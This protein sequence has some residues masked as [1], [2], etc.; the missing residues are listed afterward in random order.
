MVMSEEAVTCY[1]TGC[2]EKKFV[3]SANHGTACTFHPAVPIFHDGIKR[4]PCCKRSS[5]DFT[6]LLSYPGCSSGPHNPTRPE[7]PAPPPA[8]LIEDA[9]E[10]PAVVHQPLETRPTP[11]RTPSGSLEP[12][13]TSTMPS[14]V[15]ALNRMTTNESLASQAAPVK[16]KCENFG[17]DAEFVEGG[18][19]A[20]NCLHH[21]SPPVFHEGLQYWG[22]CQ[23]KH[24]DFE[25]MRQQPGCTHGKH[26][27]CNP[28]VKKVSCRFD[29]FDNPS[30]LTLNIYAKN[31]FPDKC[32]FLANNCMLRVNL[33]YGPEQLCF[34]K[35]FRLFSTIDPKRCVVNLNATK[36]EVKLAKEPLGSWKSIELP[37]DASNEGDS[38]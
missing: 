30:L 31:A 5:C 28:R 32:T 34:E 14:L 25:K 6:T 22:C 20:D 8:P 38:A 21:P 19:L 2:A 33:V 27:W 7:Q 11:V 10:F 17:C 37:L 9:S 24:T 1:N 18:S 35:D 29:H 13:P 4:W 23:K 16:I 15:N 3:V 36:V 12:L 26:N